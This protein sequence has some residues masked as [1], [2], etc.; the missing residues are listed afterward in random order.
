VRTNL[1]DFAQSFVQTYTPYLC[2]LREDW[3][4]P[5]VGRRVEIFYNPKGAKDGPCE[6]YKNSLA[7]VPPKELSA[8]LE[9]YLGKGSTPLA[10]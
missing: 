3:H 2:Y 8:L 10:N 4:D 1:A 6:K 5:S 7:R 9:S